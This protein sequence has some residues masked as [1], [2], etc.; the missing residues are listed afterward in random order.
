M[1]IRVIATRQRPNYDIATKARLPHFAFLPLTVLLLGRGESAAVDLLAG[2]PSGRPSGDRRRKRSHSRTSSPRARGAGDHDHP[3]DGGRR[4]ASRTTE[5]EPQRRRPGLPS[6]RAIHSPTYG[7]GPCA[8]R[9]TSLAGSAACRRAARAELP[10]RVARAWLLSAWDGARRACT[11]APRCTQAA[12]ADPAFTAGG[13]LPRLRP[14]RP[15][16][17]RDLDA[18]EAR[19][20][21]KERGASDA[22]VGRGGRRCA[23]GNGRVVGHAA[24]AR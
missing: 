7:A 24:E 9:A 3:C 13:A 18:S 16:G 10:A 21:L 14:R 20:S 23:L 11:C 2:R 5:R 22:R 8:E 1:P 17:W 4:P 19:R 12:R 15:H 6:K